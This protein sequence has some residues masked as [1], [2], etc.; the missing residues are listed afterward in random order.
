VEK[1]AVAS[2]Q[3][4]TNAVESKQ[5]EKN[6]V[7][8]KQDQKS[9]GVANASQSSVHSFISFCP[10]CVYLMTLVFQVNC[11]LVAFLF[12]ATQLPVLYFD[13]EFEIPLTEG[14]VARLANFAE[15]SF[16]CSIDDSET[17]SQVWEEV[18]VDEEKPRT[19]YT[20]TVAFLANAM[21]VAANT[22]MKFFFIFLPKLYVYFY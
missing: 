4:E 10:F 11:D 21:C 18:F 2:K 19:A 13:D 20:V 14:G 6:V 17:H 15:R 5:E 22:S 9:I 7:E 3:E 8:S 16:H 1:K 12:L